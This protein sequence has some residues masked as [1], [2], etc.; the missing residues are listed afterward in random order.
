VGGGLSVKVYGGRGGR[1]RVSAVQINAGIRY[2]LGSEAEYLKEGSIER[3]NG[4]VFF[5][6]ERS[7][8]D[9]LIPQLGAVLKF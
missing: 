5:T 8:T 1:G 9:M 2:L 4:Q 7:K 3:R 6:T